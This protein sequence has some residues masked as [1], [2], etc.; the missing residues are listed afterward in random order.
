M[1]I[2]L[3]PIFVLAGGKATRLG[4]LAAHRPKVLVEIAG[5]PFLHHLVAHLERAGVTNIV[6]CLGHLGDLVVD[7]LDKIGTA[8]K[9]DCSFDGAVPLGTGGS[10]RKALSGDDVEIGIMYGDT[11]LPISFQNA[12]S[13]FVK[14][15]KDGLMTVISGQIAKDTCNTAVRDGLVASYSK[16]N[17]T[18]DMKH[19]D[20]GLSFLH[21]SVLRQYPPDS[22]FD[23]GE[24]FSKLADD[25]NLA[26]YEVTEKYLEIG[27][28]EAVENTDRELRRI[29]S[30]AQVFSSDEGAD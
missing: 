25:G 6:L 13:A 19:I 17:R 22:S 23:L 26:A 18:D 24:V 27:T 16:T 29:F 30:S 20:Y 3:P 9:I 15:G 12:Y 14:C 4:D 28:P 10:A 21:A 8:V 7:E 5:K 1:A 2:K 11:F